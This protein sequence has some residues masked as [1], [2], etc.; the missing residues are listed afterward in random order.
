MENIGC[1]APGVEI[2]IV[3]ITNGDNSIYSGCRKAGVE[4]KASADPTLTGYRY[5][6]EPDS[7]IKS[8]SSLVPIILYSERFTWT[9]VKLKY[10]SGQ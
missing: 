7:T 6:I 9:F 8:N 2:E 3:S 10:H 4:V 5:C 1:K